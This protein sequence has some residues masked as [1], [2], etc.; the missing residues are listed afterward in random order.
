MDEVAIRTEIESW[1]NDLDDET[2]LDWCD[3]YLHGTWDTLAETLP[4]LNREVGPETWIW[5]S[6]RGWIMTKP[7]REVISTF[8]TDLIGERN[9]YWTGQLVHLM[10]H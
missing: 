7:M 3:A 6:A 4:K 10:N 8:G 2:K 1:W 9:Q 5:Q